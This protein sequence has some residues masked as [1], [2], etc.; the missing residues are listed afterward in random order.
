MAAGTLATPRSR[1]PRWVREVPV[2][3]ALEDHEPP[4]DQIVLRADLDGDLVPEIL[5]SSFVRCL[6]T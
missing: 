6:R 1:S 4:R 5:A 2:T 3:V